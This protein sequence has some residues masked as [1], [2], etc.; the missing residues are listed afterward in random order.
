MQDKKKHFSNI[1]DQYASRIYRYVFLKVN[2][3]HVAEDLSSD[4]F[5]RIWE[6]IKTDS[7]IENIQ[8]YI[9]QTA[10]NMIVNH[11]RLNSRYKVVSVEE[12]TDILEDTA[13]AEEKVGITLEMDRV[14]KALEGLSDD[15]QNYIIW[16]YLDELSVPEIA[17]I[18]GKSEESVRVGTHRALQSLRKTMQ[19]PSLA[20][21][22]E[23]AVEG[24]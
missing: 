12:K 3:H 21:K 20:T 24:V 1:Y 18:M 4:V 10:R 23:A 6:V 19:E 5:V 17:Q 15:Y 22:L 13:T 14:K 9:Y 16:R 7:K 2:S 11:Y 8:A